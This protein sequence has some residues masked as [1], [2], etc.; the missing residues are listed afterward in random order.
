MSAHVYYKSQN[1]SAVVK[2]T[3]QSFARDVY[4]LDVD[5]LKNVPMII[6][7]GV[8]SFRGSDLD[9]SSCKH[10]YRHLMNSLEGHARG[11]SGPAILPSSPRQAVQEGGFTTSQIHRFVCHRPLPHHV[12]S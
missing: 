10:A 11:T 9:N 3:P 6:L 1:T 12:R 8:S 2:L 4:Y 5:V 7:K